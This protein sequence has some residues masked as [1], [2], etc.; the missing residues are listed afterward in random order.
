MLDET[1]QRC[2]STFLAEE[3]VV[4]ES[5]G[6]EYL[7]FTENGLIGYVLCTEDDVIEVLSAKEPEWIEV[8][9]GEGTPPLPNSQNHLYMSEDKEKIQEIVDRIRD[10]NG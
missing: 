7:H 2:G 9:S 5:W 3:P 8:S 1:G 6:T 10:S 4:F